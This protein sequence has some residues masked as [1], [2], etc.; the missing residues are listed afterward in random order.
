[1]ALQ[2]KFC[3]ACHNEFYNNDVCPQ[4]GS[5]FIENV[6]PSPAS[7]YVLTVKRLKTRVIR[8]LSTLKMKEKM[9]SN[10]LHLQHLYTDDHNLL[11]LLLL[12]KQTRNRDSHHPSALRLNPLHLVL[13]TR[14]PLYL[15]PINNL[16]P[17]HQRL[18]L[19]I[20]VNRQIPCSWMD[21]GISSNSS[22]VG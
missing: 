4:C 13:R 12:H 18:P 2:L 21:T 11:S 5:D 16:R 6:T 9:I 17:L 8:L 10:P 19:Q 7:R 20:P 15:D 3:H 14:V 1:M 22:S